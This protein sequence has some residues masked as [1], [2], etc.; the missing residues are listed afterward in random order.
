MDRYT[1]AIKNSCKPDLKKLK[2]SGLRKNFEEIVATLKDDP[3]APVHGFEKL[4]PV[5]EG[6]YSR[7]LNVQHR[8]VYKVDEKRKVVEIYSAWSHYAR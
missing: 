3:F 8:I 5:S 1:I 2:K 4:Q 7:R 6:R